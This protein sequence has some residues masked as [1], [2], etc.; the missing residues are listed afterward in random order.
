MT[1]SLR[2]TDP[3]LFEAINR[4]KKQSII[5]GGRSGR[6]SEQYDVL[7][8]QEEKVN[9]YLACDDCCLVF[10]QQYRIA[11]I[12]FLSGESNS[13]RYTFTQ[14]EMRV[15]TACYAIYR[16]KFIESGAGYEVL[17]DYD[18]IEQEMI[19]REIPIRQER[20]TVSGNN[21]G[22]TVE[23]LKKLAAIS[24]IEYNPQDD[25]VILLPGLVFG[26]DKKELDN[27]YNET[28]IP[29]LEGGNAAEKEEE[30]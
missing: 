11:R 14:N 5:Y 17:T 7:L 30:S 20:A 9:D 13:L 26:I 8:E 24:M 2:S 28:L 29:W 15:Y 12:H 27:V 21:R 4:L 22:K 18:E 23:V 19:K 25:Q 6:E 3:R 16:E 10:N 1:E